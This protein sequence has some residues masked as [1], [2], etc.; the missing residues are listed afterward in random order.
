M[1]VGRDDLLA[2]GTAAYS[3]MYQFLA[4]LE[5]FGRIA[6]LTP[7]PAEVLAVSSMMYSRGD[8][9]LYCVTEDIL[10]RRAR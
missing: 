9:S 2:C 7:P 6:I 8:A 5:V 1:M 3:N 10:I 4:A